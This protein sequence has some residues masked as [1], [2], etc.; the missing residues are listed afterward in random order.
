MKAEFSRRALQIG[1]VVVGSVVTT[2]AFAAIFPDVPL[3]NIHKE[4]I[5]FLV[6]EQVINGN[7]DGNFYPDKHVNRAEMLKMLY[8]AAG[9]EPDAFQRMC[10]PDVQPGGWYEPYVCDA[11]YQHF[12]E[13]YSDGL[14]RPE[15]SV[16]RVESIKMIAEVFGISVEELT[17]ESRSV[18]KFVDV[19]LSAWYTKYLYLAFSKGIL[20]IAGHDG[21]RFF[22]DQPLLR[23]EAASYIFNALHVENMSSMSESTEEED[24]INAEIIED[25]SSD[26]PR[27]MD[28]N[29]KTAPQTAIQKISVPTDMEGLF[30]GKK[31]AVFTFDLQRD[32]TFLLYA[33]VHVEKIS[34]RLYRLEETG[35]SSEFY[36]G[37]ETNNSCKM[38][39]ALAP[40]SYQLE[41]RATFADARY[42]LSLQEEQ[43]DGND[44][45]RE[46]RG[47]VRTVPRV[48]V[49]E[50]NDTF[51]WYLF[52]VKEETNMQ[53]RFVAD[54]D[55]KCL[56]Y[57]MEDVD[58]Y[59][60]NNPEC[61]ASYAYPPGTYYVGIARTSMNT[62]NQKYTVQ[63][64]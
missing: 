35:F 30:D 52:V 10:F 62:G 49:L 63:L 60:F 15:K 3:G 24:A 21:P 4:N 39:V 27:Q 48:A 11:A 36:L 33:T 56:V 26:R 31:P 64:E 37:L 18:V 45:F 20:P 14:F 6:G 61:N 44:G 2:M 47:L 50:S 23:G 54:N 59:G 55:A 19:S 42:G 22:P 40:G 5:E 58:L 13:G 25:T 17:E 1:S 16:S 34:C 46:A 43:G 32:S 28:P 53:L 57:A 29:A 8:H 38:R 7:P 12:V 9:R 51:D 41:L